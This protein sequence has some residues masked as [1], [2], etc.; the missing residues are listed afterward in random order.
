MSLSKINNLNFFLKNLLL[1]NKNISNKIKYSKILKK[2]FKNKY[3]NTKI[4][5]SGMNTNKNIKQVIKYKSPCDK[6]IILNFINLID[7]DSVMLEQNKNISFSVVTIQSELPKT[8]DE[9][10]KNINEYINCV[11]SYI[12]NIY[13]EYDIIVND[14]DLDEKNF[15]NFNRF[16]IISWNLEL[17]KYFCLIWKLLEKIYLEFDQYKKNTTYSNTTDFLF[18][19]EQELNNTDLKK[20]FD[21]F[22]N[23][24]NNLI[25]LL[26]EIKDIFDTTDKDKYLLSFNTINIILDK[27]IFVIDFITK[28]LTIM[29]GL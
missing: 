2:N 6:P 9:L 22:C 7:I 16:K 5:I 29:T 21:Y 4:S 17:K 10:V 24:I 19:F 14:S 12:P 13:Q 20:H 28:N 1:I 23:N 3:N 15:N 25:I 27:Y 18:F 26:V 8:I 11:D